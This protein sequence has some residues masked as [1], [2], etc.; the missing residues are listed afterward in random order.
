[1]TDFLTFRRGKE[2]LEYPHSSTVLE[3]NAF[4]PQIAF[5]P[6]SYGGKKVP[7]PLVLRGEFVREGQMIARGSGIGA[8]NAY[9]SIP[10][11]VY[12]FVG[13]D[14]PDGRTIHSVAVKL[15]GSFDILG[16]PAANYS[17]KNSASSELLHAIDFAGVLNTA[18][19]TGE[20]LAYQLRS[21]I[22]S[23]GKSV[24]INLFDK[25][26]SCGLDAILFDTFYNEVAEGIGIA[27]KILNASTVVC[28]HK[29]GKNDKAKLEKISEACGNAAVEF[30]KA[31]P[32]YPFI[33]N[34]IPKKN[35]DSLWLDI[36]TALQTYEAVRTN[37]PI[38]A[39]YV[40]ISGKAVNEPKVLKARIG[41]PI[42]NLI[43][44]CGGFKSNPE[45]I[46]LN[47]LMCG[48][49]ID[50]L[51]IPVTKNL[52]SIHICGK[53][54]VKHYSPSECINCGLCFNSCP[55]YLE[56]KKIVKAI[57]SGNI[58]D[59]IIKQISLCKKC[60]CCSSCCPARIPLSAIIAET[61]EQLKRERN[62]K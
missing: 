12:D 61:R 53:E 31:S 36:S 34:S 48:F 55:L 17:W 56:P 21:A 29:F 14:L 28:I 24:C 40:L 22:K 62:I 49:S 27:A 1:M 60:S 58:N 30:I 2:L 44:E 39:S 13:F 37:N 54:T 16:K 50:N 45:H 4:L 38:T 42:G 8:V 57:E 46:I 20:A 52:K 26:P 10:G 47:G 59:E 32:C 5:I 18:S 7:E 9:S 19:T 3:G 11:I 35:A 15:E 41:T 51:D 25:D 6:I 23:G 43:E 33:R